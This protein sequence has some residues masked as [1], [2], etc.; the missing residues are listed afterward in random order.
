MSMVT[1]RSVRDNDCLTFEGPAE[2]PPQD[3]PPHEVALMNIQNQTVKKRGG[4]EAGFSIRPIKDTVVPPQGGWVPI[5]SCPPQNL[6]VG[7][8]KLHFAA[9]SLVA[10]GVQMQQFTPQVQGGVHK[11]KPAVYLWSNR[12]SSF[13]VGKGQHIGKLLD[14]NSLHIG[15]LMGL[16]S[17]QQ[18]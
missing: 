4:G 7:G 12:N 1:N 11:G 2:D 17:V 16:N 3:A 6:T 8:P 15:Q 9:Q 5:K 14:L 18:G 13:Q 10:K